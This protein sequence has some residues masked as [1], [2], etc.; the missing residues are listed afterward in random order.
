MVVS[1]TT[2]AFAA[3]RLSLELV[4]GPLALLCGTPCI[5][6]SSGLLLRGAGHTVLCSIH[7]SMPNS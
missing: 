4:R 2:V 7:Y 6:H 5:K 1:L 3:L